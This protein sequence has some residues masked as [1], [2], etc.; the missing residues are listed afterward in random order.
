MSSM[1]ESEVYATEK[2]HP[3][4]APRLTAFMREVAQRWPK[5][6]VVLKVHS[7]NVASGEWWSLTWE[8]ERKD[9]VPRL[10]SGSAMTLD[11]CV[12]RA[13]AILE[14]ND[15]VQELENPWCSKLGR[16]LGEFED[17]EGI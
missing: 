9:G 7:R 8:E 3:F 6:E 16:Y 11:K 1:V 15:R 5:G 14:Q 17:G 2:R 12:R 10:F 4:L 13:I